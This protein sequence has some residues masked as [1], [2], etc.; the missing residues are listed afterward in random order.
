MVEVQRCGRAT[1]APPPPQKP[2]SWAARLHAL[3]LKNLAFWKEHTN[4]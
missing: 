1:P 4:G 3:N 2:L